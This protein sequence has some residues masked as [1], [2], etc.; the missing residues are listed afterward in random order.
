MNP[1]KPSPLAASVQCCAG[2]I[3]QPMAGV[4]VKALLTAMLAVIVRAEEVPM[5]QTALTA[6]LRAGESVLGRHAQI[7]VGYKGVQTDRDGRVHHLF[8]ARDE[9]TVY[10]CYI[11][12]SERG[13]EPGREHSF[14][15]RVSRI[16]LQ[17]QDLRDKRIYALWLDVSLL[18]NRPP[19]PPS[20]EHSGAGG[21]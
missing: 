10:L 6:A 16:E 5:P 14:T 12:G 21:P 9:H 8:T 13:R 7:T 2:V 4:I 11:M 19:H 1:E 20:A 15:G 3:R 18:Q 17:E